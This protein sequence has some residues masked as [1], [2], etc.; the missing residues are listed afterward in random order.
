MFNYAN[1]LYSHDDADINAIMQEYEV[2]PTNDEANFMKDML[3]TS[4]LKPV[5]NENLIKFMQTYSPITNFF[6]EHDDLVHTVAQFAY[7]IQ[8]NSNSNAFKTYIKVNNNKA[9]ILKLYKFAQNTQKILSVNKI[10]NKCYSISDVPRLNVVDSLDKY[11]EKYN[12]QAILSSNVYVRTMYV[13]MTA[14]L[15]NGYFMRC[16]LHL[17]KKNNVDINACKSEPQ[18]PLIGFFSET[19]L[20]TMLTIDLNETIHLL[21]AAFNGIKSVYIA[22]Y[23]FYKLSTRVCA[24]EHMSHLYNTFLNLHHILKDTFSVTAIVNMLSLEDKYTFQYVSYEFPQLSSFYCLGMI[25]GDLGDSSG[26]LHDAL[27]TATCNVDEETGINTI[28]EIESPSRTT[29]NTHFKHIYNFSRYKG[30]GPFK[31]FI[32]NAPHLKT[33]SK[34][35]DMHYALVLYVVALPSKGSK[36]AMLNVSKVPIPLDARIEHNKLPNSVYK[37]IV[38]NSDSNDDAIPL[39]LM[40]IAASYYNPF[41]EAVIKTF[42]MSE[43]IK[44]E[45]VYNLREKYIDIYGQR[46]YYITPAMFSEYYKLYEIAVLIAKNNY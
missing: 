37:Q 35:F 1:I 26:D 27:W 23:Y 46:Y 39:N 36:M 5:S 38:Q 10:F 24:N 20:K 4:D 19:D 44:T 17:A 18:R 22:I 33:L 40:I 6:N 7:P 13:F 42:P 2:R 34:Q 45:Y 14:S 21:P 15:V 9:N 16:L 32:Q 12:L 8:F 25:T 29:Y 41:V 31:M 43:R 3:N 28:A 30:D 11:A